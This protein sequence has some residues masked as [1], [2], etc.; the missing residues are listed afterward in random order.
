MKPA[1]PVTRAR[2]GDAPCDPGLS[3]VGDVTAEHVTVAV[4]EAAL[5]EQVGALQRVAWSS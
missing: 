4:S 5:A 3:L 1:P 2:I